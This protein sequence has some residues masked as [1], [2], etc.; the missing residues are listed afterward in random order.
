MIL[1]IRYILILSDCGICL[2][3]VRWYHAE[4]HFEDAMEFAQTWQ[5]QREYHGLDLF[6][7]SEGLSHLDSAKCLLN[8]DFIVM[9]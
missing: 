8:F 2:P 1:Y 6:G 4:N 5:G 3:T 7:F 9:L